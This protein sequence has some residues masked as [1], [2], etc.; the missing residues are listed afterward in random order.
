MDT[1][2]DIFATTLSI[3]Y[4][5][6]QGISNVLKLNLLSTNEEPKDLL[7]QLRKRV[8]YDMNLFE[9]LKEGLSGE[10]SDPNYFI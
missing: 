6:Y 8:A 1:E 5:H 9:A 3:F 2:F 10:H 4:I 7:R